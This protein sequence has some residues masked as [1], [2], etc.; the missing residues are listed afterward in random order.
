MLAKRIIPMLLCRGRQLI[1]GAKFQ[2]QRRVGTVPQAIEIYQD[3]QADELVLIDIGATEEKR[4]IDP[5]MVREL[6][7]SLFTPLTVAGGLKDC[8]DA[9]SLLEAG[10]DKIAFGKAAWL[11]PYQIS[12]LAEKA[13]SQAV[14]ALIDHDEDGR[15]MIN[16]GQSYVHARAWELANVLQTM[17]VGELVLTDVYREGTME[18]LN[19]RV[20]E[21]VVETVDVPVIGHGGIGSY[22][23]MLRGLVLG[24]SGVG[25]GSL[26]QF[27]EATPK[28]AADYLHEQGVTVRRVSD[29]V[30]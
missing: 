3:R 25:V 16:N 5:E 19:L 29:E 10:A 1:K 6:T 9:L 21:R 8:A 13:G 12:K 27:T 7:R 2:G 18:G 22:N 17:G 24:L 11:E 20:L 23:D 28:G 30:G 14:V 4:T 26:F 15:V